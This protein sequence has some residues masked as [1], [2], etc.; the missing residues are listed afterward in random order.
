M[1]DANA[2]WRHVDDGLLLA[3]RVTP[4]ASADRIEGPLSL[5][6]GSV[7]LA[8]KVRAVPDKGAANKAVEALIAKAFGVRKSDVAVTS[9]ST[10]RLKTVR[11]DG[12]PGALASRAR[13]L[14]EP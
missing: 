5:D 2:F 4:K 10:S 12:E 7:R 13:T 11:I 6:D 14:V 8:L 9:G 3:V 1:A